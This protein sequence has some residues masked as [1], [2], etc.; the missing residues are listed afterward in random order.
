MIKLYNVKVNNIPAVLIINP[1]S[2]HTFS[3]N[4]LKAKEI[5]DKFLRRL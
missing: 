2:E 4:I 5:V 3:K 1:N